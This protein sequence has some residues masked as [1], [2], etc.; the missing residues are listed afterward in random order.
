M[1][2]YNYAFGITQSQECSAKEH[3]ENPTYILSMEEQS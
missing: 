1:F 3:L 2:H